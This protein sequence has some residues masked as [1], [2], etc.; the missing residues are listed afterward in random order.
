M[1]KALED[2]MKESEM[3]GEKRGME[4]GM[5]AGM[6]EGEKRGGQRMARNLVRFMR[7]RALPDGMLHEFLAQQ[8]FSPEQIAEICAKQ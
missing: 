7:E 8:N 3:K 5:E 4:A 2:M 1:C 6:A